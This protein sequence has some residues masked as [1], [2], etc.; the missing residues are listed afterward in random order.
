MC[1]EKCTA[2]PLVEF[3]CF[4]FFSTCPVLDPVDVQC[5]SPAE[6]LPLLLGSAGL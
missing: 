3:S 1:K 2:L 4:P 5:L 6:S